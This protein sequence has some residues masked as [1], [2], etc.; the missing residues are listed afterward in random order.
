MDGETP[1]TGTIWCK[2]KLRPG[3]SRLSVV[4]YLVGYFIL[5]TEQMMNTSFTSFLLEDS[6]GIDDNDAGSV[7]GYMGVAGEIAAVV[8]EFPIGY[9]MDTIGRRIPC[10]L[11][12]AL[13]GVGYVLSP[14][15][16]NI[17]GLYCMRALVN[18]GALPILLGPQ[19]VDYIEDESQGAFQ[20]LSAVVW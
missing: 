12:I 2:I 3:V 13:I 7:L 18:V 4:A 8:S 6:Y 9:I 10:V 20:T 15:F 16:K 1:H 19:K 17:A 14:M 11:G 5:Q